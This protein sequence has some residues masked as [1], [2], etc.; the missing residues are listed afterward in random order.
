M[1]A[2]GTDYRS[3][4][5][6]GRGYGE[7]RPAE[8][9]LASL[10]R[11]ATREISRLFRQEVELAKVE[12]TE[13]AAKAARNAA[14]LIA[15]IVLALPGLMVLLIGLG[16]ALSAGLE[17]LGVADTLA[18]WLG[19]TILGALFLLIGGLLVM[20]GV[21]TLRKTSMV[22]HKTIETLRETGEWAK[23]HGGAR[24]DGD[25]AHQHTTANG[26]RAEEVTA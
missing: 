9:S 23:A 19:P 21:N 4:S 6:M 7:A 5:R 16:F 17:A 11:D 26:A 2:F 8:P 13:K 18:Y 1:T 24:R 14:A 22:P 3:A 15:G 25:P 10:I 12:T 20:K